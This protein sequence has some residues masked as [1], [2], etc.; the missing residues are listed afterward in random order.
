M[1]D[2]LMFVG[3]ESYPWP[4]DF[5]EEAERIG[6]SKKVSR[7]SIPY[8]E[9]GQARLVFVHPRAIVNVT[10]EGMNLFDLACELALEYEE[11]LDYASEDDLRDFICGYVLSEENEGVSILTHFLRNA[12]IARDLGRL[13]EKYGIEYHPGVFGFSYVTGLQYVLRDEETE[14]PDDLRGIEGIEAVRVEYEG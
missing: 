14:L 8:I 4:N 5:A 9:P 3:Q 11:G 10:A 7:A 2:L 12:D 13:E 6:P 1:S